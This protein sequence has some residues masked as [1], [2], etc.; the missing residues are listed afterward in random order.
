MK[1]F[2]LSIEKIGRTS[3]FLMR[4]FYTPQPGEINPKKSNMF[5]RILLAAVG[6]IPILLIV[7]G[8]VVGLYFLVTGKQV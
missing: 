7:A 4:F 3:F 6:W 1:K 5:I 8:M 2:L